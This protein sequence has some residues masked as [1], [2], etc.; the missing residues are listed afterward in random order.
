M[1][2]ARLGLELK[3][4]KPTFQRM[5]VLQYLQN[6][7]N[8]PTADMIYQEISKSIPTMSRTTVYNTI[9]ILVESNLVN[10][11]YITS[12]EVRYDA[13]TE[14]HH[15]VFCNKC[16]SIYDLNIPCQ[17][18]KKGEIEGHTVSEMHGYF[19][20]VCANCNKKGRRSK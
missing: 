17:T 6:N 18:F 15:H 9:K 16:E 3:G 8:H 1:K 12:N 19:M 7:L 13:M 4:I 10:P 11:V 20:G 2:N 14:S 5:A